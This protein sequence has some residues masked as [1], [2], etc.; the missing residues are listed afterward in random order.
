MW[1][2]RFLKAGTEL[3]P[4]DAVRQVDLSELEEKGTI[5]IHFVAVRG[6]G[7]DAWTQVLTGIEAI[8]AL[9]TLYPAALEGNRGVRWLRR[10]WTRHNLLGHPLMEIL[11]RL[12]FPHLGLRIH[13]ATIPGVDKIRKV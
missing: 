7:T 10:S 9:E 13:D 6:S 4:V 1:A 8:E 3:Y 2:R 11:S 12:G 5:A